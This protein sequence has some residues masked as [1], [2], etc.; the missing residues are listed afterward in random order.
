MDNHD[1]EKRLPLTQN[2]R[3]QIRM[4]TF[5]SRASSLPSQKNISLEKDQIPLRG[6][7]MALRPPQLQYEQKTNLDKSNFPQRFNSLI[8]AS[9]QIPARKELVV[10]SRD[11][12]LASPAQLEPQ[13]QPATHIVQQGKEKSQQESGDRQFSN[14]EIQMA[15]EITILRERLANVSEENTKLKKQ[16]EDQKISFDKLSAQAYKKI[17]DLLTDRTVMTIEINSLKTQVSYY[18]HRWKQWKSNTKIGPISQTELIKMH[19]DKVS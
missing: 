6:D 10:M 11:Q 13:T 16:M 1:G 8:N 12:S 3:D 17:K 15:Q 4:P 5:A 19:S 9:E 18:S 7:S 2:H 14:L